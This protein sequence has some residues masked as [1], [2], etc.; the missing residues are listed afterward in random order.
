MS[1]HDCIGNVCK[2]LYILEDILFFKSSSLCDIVC[3]GLNMLNIL[4]KSI[5]HI[6]LVYSYSEFVLIF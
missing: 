6:F 3:V 1:C 4:T 2:Y 5:V